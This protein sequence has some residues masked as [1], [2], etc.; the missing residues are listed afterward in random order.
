M[1]FLANENI[2]LAALQHLRNKGFNISS[3]S[4]LSPGASDE[5]VIQI[6][7]NERRILITFDKDFS[8]FVFRKGRKSS[9]I[10]LL[11]FSP[12]TSEFVSKQLLAL[13]QRKDLDF[14]GYITVLD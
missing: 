12:Q 11:R 9:G 13:L 5:A 10:I 14:D 6:A 8:E 3:V 4:E 7:S 1:R 2:P